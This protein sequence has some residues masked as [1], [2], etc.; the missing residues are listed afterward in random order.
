MPRGKSSARAVLFSGD[1]D[2]GECSMDVFEGDDPVRKAEGLRDSCAPDFPSRVWA[3]QMNEAA[4]E[5]MGARRMREWG[6]EDAA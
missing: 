4:R 3:I 6:F 5:Q 1:P 2:T